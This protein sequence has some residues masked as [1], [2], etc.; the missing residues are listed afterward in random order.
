MH[1]RVLALVRDQRLRFLAVG[2]T[3]TVVGYV[4]FLVLNEWVFGGLPFGYLL[5]L[6]VSYAIAI[7][8]AFVLYRRFV[9]IVRGNVLV[10]FVRFVGVY[11]VSL[12]INLVVLPLLVEVVHLPPFLAQAIILVVTTVVSYLGHRYFSFRRRVAS[13][14]VAEPEGTTDADERAA[15]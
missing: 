2:A 3:N 11:L 5:S 13:G 10:D 9:F 8:M 1:H 12:G 15:S 6:V 4:L 14:V 7:V